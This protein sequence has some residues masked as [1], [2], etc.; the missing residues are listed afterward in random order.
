LAEAARV[1][2]PGGGIII[3]VS[4]GYLTPD[5]SIVRGQIGKDGELDLLAPWRKILEIASLTLPIGFRD[6]QFHDL[7]SELAISAIFG[8]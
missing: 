7:K 6:W 3:S 8:E 4:N 5:G 1:L 2:K